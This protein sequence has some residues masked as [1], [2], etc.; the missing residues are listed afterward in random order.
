MR[1]VAFVA[2]FLVTSLLGAASAE[3]MSCQNRLVRQGDA[4]ARVIQLC[5]DPA[6]I[7]QRNETR[8]RTV[9]GRAPDGTIIQHIVTVTVVVEVWTYD[10]GP[11]RFM[12]QLAFENGVLLRI[13]T[14]GY[15]TVGYSPR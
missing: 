10:F 3:A 11:Q 8:S 1:H 4:S 12:R 6:Q 13:D 5:G 9:V 15:G 7:V 2:A 14:L